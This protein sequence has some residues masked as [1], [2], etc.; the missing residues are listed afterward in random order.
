MSVTKQFTKYVSQNIFGMLGISCYI[1]ADTFFISKAAGANGITVLNLVLPI[2]NL[3]FA[4]GSMVGVGAATR[5]A[6]LRAR[7][8]K[9]ADDYF[10]NGIFWV[11]IISVL[12]ILGG[13]FLPDKILMVMGADE[14]IVQLGTG[15]TRIFLLF[16]PFF[17]MNY[18]FSSFVRNDNDPSL[19]MVATMTG[20]LSNI[21]FDYV[22]MFIFGWGLEGAAAATAA[23]P[24]LSI[25][26]CLIH[27]AKKDNT[28]CFKVKKPEARKL[29]E[30]CQLG[31]P[32]FIGELSS[33][34]TTTVFNFLILGL[35]G[36][37]GVAAYG[38]IANFSIV[39][40]SIFNG[41]SQGSQPLISSYYGKGEKKSVEKVLKMGMVTSIGI[42]VMLCLAVFGFTEGL[43]SLFNSE[44]NRELAAYAFRGMRLYFI[45]FL[46]AGLNIVGTGYLSATERARPAFVA[47][48]LRGVVAIVGC[49]VVLAMIFAMDGV[50]I[51]F[52]AAEAITL[53]VTAFFI[54]QATR[55]ERGN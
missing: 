38:V 2:Y 42:A 16:S 40:I 14:T 37:I 34:V 50:W 29:V 10:F 25:A 33:G 54:R 52:A 46:F 9:S 13:I 8:E 35:V 6:I 1:I 5:F 19:A 53:L 7:G 39:A 20:S 51:S 45:G 36:N 24:I 23:S 3:I 26:I 41:I 44:N 47:S 32:A 27:F 55:M 43:V 31:V 18:I 49:S 30:S 22:F 28:L 12:F 17:M 21:V 4:I 11:C 15:Y 48:V